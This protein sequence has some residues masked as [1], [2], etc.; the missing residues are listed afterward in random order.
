MRTELV[1]VPSPALYFVSGVLQ[2]PE[3][4]HVQT[5][6]PEAAVE[7]FDVRVVCRRTGSGIIELDLIEV[8]PSVQR[9]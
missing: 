8:R 9:S 7:G 2:R 5:F 3:P 6:V 1:V 4:V